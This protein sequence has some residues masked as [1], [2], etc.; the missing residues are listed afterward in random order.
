[1]PKKASTT[2]DSWQAHFEA[3]AARGAKLLAAWNAHPAGSVIVADGSLEE[4]F[5]L[6]DFP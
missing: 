5:T 4:G 2:D 6:V 3:P 1:M